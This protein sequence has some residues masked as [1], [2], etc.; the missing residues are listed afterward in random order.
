MGGDGR[1]R[2][3][4]RNAP[5][6]GVADDKLVYAYV[7][8]MIRY[9]LG[10]K[11]VLASVPTLPCVDPAAREQVLDRLDQLVLK[12]VDG[13][14]GAGIVIGP[15]AGRAELDRVAEAI[16]ATP[17]GWVAQDLVG[18]STH[19]TFTDGALQPQAVDLRVF[20]VQSPA[21]AECPRSTCCPRR[22]HGSPARRDDRELLARRW[23][24]GH[25]GAGL[26]RLSRR[27]AGPARPAPG[28]RRRGRCR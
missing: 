18:I 22:C 8:E 2:V 26:R 15:Y 10:E 17:A 13:Y 6:N 28:R 9:Y 19:P 14:G 4:L 12:P 1:G 3:A 20:A 16:R 5:G 27:A 21:P 11:P 23:G 25:L 7:P 24:E